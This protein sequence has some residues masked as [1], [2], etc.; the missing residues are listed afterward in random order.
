M[1]LFAA[2][3]VG[4]F[5]HS[6]YLQLLINTPQIKI[7]IRK[8]WRHGK[9][10]FKKMKKNFWVAAFCFMFFDFMSEIQTGAVL[11]AMVTA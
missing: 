9:K 10:N 3:E 8:S 7:I 2:C 11:L 6:T 4:V 5:A 1:S